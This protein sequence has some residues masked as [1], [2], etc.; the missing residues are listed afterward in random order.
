MAF[1]R[2]RIGSCF[3]TALAIAVFAVAAGRPADAEDYVRDKVPSPSAKAYF[4]TVPDKLQARKVGRKEPQ[5]A[6]EGEAYFT[7]DGSISIPS[8]GMVSFKMAGRCMDPH[9]PAP[10]S[11]EPMQ[12]VDR[13]RT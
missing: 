6:G 3:A 1:P 13:S 5:N 2:H 7:E 4:A 12:F 9:L 10:A 8:R 11:G